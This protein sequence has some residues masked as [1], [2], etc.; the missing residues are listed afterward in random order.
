MAREG[1]RRTGEEERVVTA[2]ERKTLGRG[3]MERGGVEAISCEGGG[4]PG[5]GVARGLRKLTVWLREAPAWR[6]V[7]EECK[8]RE[9]D[10]AVDDV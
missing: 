5:S 1:P 10:V 6:V 9:V 3:R 8:D 2:S 4:D 7:V